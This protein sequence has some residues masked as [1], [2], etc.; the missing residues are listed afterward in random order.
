MTN[1]LNN[2]KRDMIIKG[3]SLNTQK[4]YTYMIKKFLEYCKD[5]S[6]EFN[7]LN[8]KEYLY[9][10][11]DKKVSLTSL[12]QSIGAIKFFLSPLSTFL[13]N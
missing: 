6:K 2:F 9:H 1:Y 7:C 12:K 11:V 4:S 3:F 10:L 5:Y 13:M 8:V